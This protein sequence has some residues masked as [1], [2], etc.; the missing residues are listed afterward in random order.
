VTPVRRLFPFL[1]VL[2]MLSPMWGGQCERL[3]GQISP[4]PLA[5]AH[6]GL[7][8]SLKCTQCHAG[9]KEGMTA[10]CQSCHR[11]VAWLVVR[12]RG[13][14]GSRD[15]KGQPC[16]SCHPEHAGAD[17]QMIKWPDGNRERFDHRRAGWLLQQSH[18]QL[19]C[20]D[21][22]TGKFQ[23]SPAASLTPDKRSGGFSGLERS[24]ASC[25]EDVHRGALGTECAKCHDAGK[26][27]VTPD[28]SHNSTAYPLTNRHAE[29]KCDKCHLDSRVATKNDSAGRPIPVYKPLPHRSCADC[30][31]DPH[32]G[33]LGPTCT[34]CHSTAGF[35]QIDRGNF[36]HDRTRYPLKGRHA[37]VRCASCHQ[38]FST[39]LAK[40]P[41]FQSCATCHQD[42]HGGSAMLA[43]KAVDCAAC[44]AV[45]GF[46]PATLTVEQHRNTKYPLEG[47]HQ[48]VT[49][50]DCHRKETGSVVTARWGSARVVI[51][52]AFARCV[53][54]HKDAHGGQLAARSD[55]GECTACHRV[56]GWTPSLFDAA[57]HAKLRLPLGGRHGEVACRACHGDERTGLPPLPRAVTLGT[58]RFLFHVTEIECVTCHTDP[59]RGRFAAGGPRAKLAGCTGCHD[60]RAFR[61]TTAD[62]AAHR[63]FG[64]ALE[65]AHRAT[66]CVGCH[67][68]MKR[69]PAK[70]SSLTRGGATFPELGFAAKTAC[71]DCHQT[72]HGDQFASRKDQGRCDACHGVDAFAPASAFDHNRDAAFSLK[73]A[74]EGVPCNRCHASATGSS[75]PHRL[76]YRPVSG[77]CESCHAGKEAR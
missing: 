70:R 41:A 58:A 11:E 39:P 13:Y 1:L 63:N 60:T 73:G 72:P 62:V 56:A 48:T 32:N 77:K 34:G 64:F 5:R 43:G 50:A 20:A 31:I 74:H 45:S 71:V 28:F 9:K 15:V 44:H 7:E 24:C 51:R 21:C 26:W 29:V 8:G 55:P 54:C 46:S 57:Q 52:P 53:D 23:I 49:C 65:G 75:E 61:P 10:Q 33:R 47:K 3:E 36:D 18:A 25:H 2:L 68:E 22:H 30:H 69:P 40:K 38:D 27:T 35:R 37:A 14:H 17:F 42:V 59:H 76:V 66:P 12:D 19:A 16:A 6:A 67:G 4:G